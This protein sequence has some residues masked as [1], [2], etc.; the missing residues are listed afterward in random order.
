MPDF[1][2]RADANSQIATGHVM[3]CMAIADAL[4]KEGYRCIFV[5][6]DREGEALV[7]SRG[8]QVHCLDSVWNQ[9][10]SETDK[11]TALIRERQIDMIL[12]DSY[13]VTED[14]LRRI[15]ALTKV[16][17][18]DDL[19]RFLYPVDTVLNSCIYADQFHYE[20]RYRAA[21]LA[22]RF[23]LGC[24]YAPLREEFSDLSYSVRERAE[25]I[26]ITTGGTDHYNVAGKLAAKIVQAEGF[27]DMT[28]HI[29]AGAY[30][31]NKNWLRELAGRY[32]RIVLHENV[33]EMAKLMVSCDI[34][35]TAGGTTTYELCA[36]G[37]PSIAVALADNQLENLK[38]FAEEK[39]L[40]YAGDV[41]E[42]ETVVLGKVMELLEVLEGSRELRQQFSLRMQKK[43][44]KNGC[45]RIVNAML[46]R[47]TV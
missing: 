28:I 25:N 4:Q 20:E 35:I 16:Y 11:M 29:I 18:I 15:S 36:C 45:Q 10:D 44:I 14:Y 9:M 27:R 33:T 41:T 31:E 2:I 21:G 26:L 40:A 30:N 12:I 7:K 19:D 3:R 5:M 47:K 34:A 42:N 8:Y 37:I 39:L 22:T 24:E 6:A 23:L 46:G 43:N 17:Y 32:S 1:Y 13:F 38:R